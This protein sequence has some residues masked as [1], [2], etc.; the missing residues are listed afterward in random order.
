MRSGPRVSGA[1]VLDQMRLA[2]EQFG[3]EAHDR[4]L[5]AMSVEGGAELA[6]LMPMTWCSLA[7]TTEYWN[8]LGRATNQDVR[9]IHRRLTRLGL[10]R[11]FSTFWRILARLTTMEA[12]V[13][14]AAVIF[15][16]AYDRGAMAAQLTGP[17]C[18]EVVVTGWPDMPDLEIDA[19]TS[20]I[21]ALGH[22]SGRSKI[23][24]KWQRR[25]GAIVGE[26]MYSG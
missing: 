8:E 13:K 26:I 21:E 6:A 24:V 22:L 18:V 5:A 4:C 20:A 16:K 10:E 23:A 25:S 11:T 7:T 17:G 9:V 14:R 1:V 19:L 15:G 3:K 2:E 12:L